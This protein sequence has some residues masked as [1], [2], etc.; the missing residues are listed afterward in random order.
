MVSGISGFDAVVG[1][2]PTRA[3]LCRETDCCVPVLCLVMPAAAGCGGKCG[4]RD[5]GW[6]GGVAW[7]GLACH[8]ADW[9]RVGSEGARQPT[10]SGPSRHRVGKGHRVQVGRRGELGTKSSYGWPGHVL[11]GRRM[12]L[13]AECPFAG[14]G[15]GGCFLRRGP[16]SAPAFSTEARHALGGM[17]MLLVG[18]CRVATWWSEVAG[19]AGSAPFSTAPS[20]L[21]LA[22]AS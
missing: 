2:P 18:V 15:R 7:S 4:S 17:W 12:A 14:S 10:R 11:R 19:R 6:S 20:L 9:R 22:S 21:P 13:V 8:R 3:W 16:R 5:G 1:F